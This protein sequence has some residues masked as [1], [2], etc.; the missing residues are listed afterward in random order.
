MA[1]TCLEGLWRAA[2]T[3]LVMLLP[4][5]VAPRQR[6]RCEP[7]AHHSRVSCSRAPRRYLRRS[8]THALER[9]PAHRRVWNAW[10]RTT[11]ELYMRPCRAWSVALTAATSHLLAAC[12]TPWAMRS[13]SGPERGLPSCIGVRHGASRWQAVACLSEISCAHRRSPR[14]S[15]HSSA[16]PP[17]CSRLASSR[18]RGGSAVSPSTFVSPGGLKPSPARMVTAFSAQRA[19]VSLLE[20]SLS[21]WRRRLNGAEGGSSC[22]RA[23]SR[24]SPQLSSRAA[25]GPTRATPPPVLLRVRASVRG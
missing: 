14:R 11:L 2:E 15:R 8:L 1:S 4:W 9:S 19:F 18:R 20:Q 22:C 3:R 25:R 21:A 23:S 13:A 12:S 5:Q 6:P 24:T 16:R 7:H 10:C 17:R